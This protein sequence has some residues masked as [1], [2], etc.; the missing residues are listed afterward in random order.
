MNNA[1]FRNQWKIFKNIGTLNN[2]QQ[3]EK[4][5]NY[6]VFKT[7]CHTKKFFT[8]NLLAIEMKKLKYLCINCL[9]IVELYK[10]VT[11]QFWLD[12]VEQKYGKKVKL[13]LMDT[14]SFIVYIKI[15]DVYE[16]IAKKI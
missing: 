7:N 11:Y 14:D 4:E 2:L 3:E 9:S 8:Q 16:N 10:T 13:C 5:R 6:L 15:D 12:Y 1:V